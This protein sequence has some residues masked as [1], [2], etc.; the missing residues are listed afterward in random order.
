MV[1][2]GQHVL[3]VVRPG[4]GARRLEFLVEAGEENELAVELEES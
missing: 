2:A 3:E 4:Y 1:D